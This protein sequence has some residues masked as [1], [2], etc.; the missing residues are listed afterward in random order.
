MARSS[1]KRNSARA[2]AS[3][4]LPTPV[5]PRKRNDPMGR[6]GS[7]RPAR[8]RRTAL[9]TAATASSW[10]TTRRWRCSSRRIS[11]SISP[12]MSRDTGTPVQRLTTSATSSSST[13]S[14]SMR[15]PAWSFC[16]GLLGCGEAS[17]AAPGRRAV[18]QLGGALQV[19]LALGPFG[20][21]PG[22]LDLLLD[23]RGWRRWP[24]S[25][26]SQ[27]AVRR[28]TSL[29]DLGEFGLEGGEPLLAR[30][31]RSPCAGRRARSPT[32][33]G[34]APARRSPRAWS[35]SRCAGGWRPRRS[36]RWPC[37]AG[38]GR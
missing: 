14:L 8:E 38:G 33:G 2:R 10:P 3:S 5:G 31:R 35:R 32:G 15:S 26:A 24:P 34:G 37:R 13:S 28:P 30:R 19:A 20:G 17:S 1:S 36:G 4:V 18:A 16:Q 27:W 6:C 21:G 11:F 23:R 7:A 25:P 22:L 9:A 12:S 29:G